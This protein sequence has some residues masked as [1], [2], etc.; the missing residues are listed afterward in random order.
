MQIENI[1]FPELVL[2][3]KKKKKKVHFF[4]ACLQIPAWNPVFLF[5][6]CQQISI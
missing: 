3:P 4:V 6:A 2:G 5:I 1:D